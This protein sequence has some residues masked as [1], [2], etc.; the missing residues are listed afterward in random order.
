MFLAQTE[1]NIKIPF[2]TLLEQFNTHQ[3]FS[4]PVMPGAEAL[5]LIFIGDF[6]QRVVGGAD[7]R[8]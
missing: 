5:R 2:K 1:S 6:N 3:I 4:W 8:R 7:D